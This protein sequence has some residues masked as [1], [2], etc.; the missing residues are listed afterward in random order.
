MKTMKSERKLITGLVVGVV[1]CATGCGGGAGSSA[2]VNPTT[3]SP[4]PVATKT[5][6]TGTI[7]GFGSVYLNGEKHDTDNAGIYRDDDLSDQSNLAIGMVVKIKGE[8]NQADFVTYDEDI[9]GPLD[10]IGTNTLTVLGQ[11]VLVSPATIIDDGLSVSDFVMGDIL[12]VSGF[13]NPADELDAGYIERKAFIDV[14]EYE[15][16]GRIRNLDTTAQEF[17]IGGLRVNY[18]AAEL[19]DIAQLENNLLV[20]VEDESLAYSAGDF[21]LFA[22]EV[23]GMSPLAIDDDIDPDRDDDD[24]DFDNDFDDVEFEDFISEIIDA[25]NF[26]LNG[27]Q[28]F[29]DSGT[30]FV[31]GT[32]DM[33]AQGS[34]VEVEG[35]VTD[36]LLTAVKIKFSDN[37]ARIDGL[38]ENL[39]PLTV[40]GVV[41]LAN[42][43]TEVKDDRDDVDPF[44]LGDL[45]INNFVEVEGNVTPNGVLASEI[46]RDDD[47]ETRIRGVVTAFNAEEQTL[48]ILGVSLVVGS[49]TKYEED[50]DSSDDGDDGS[51][52]DGLGDDS[53][54]AEVFFAA[55]DVGQ[56]VVEAKWNATI[57]DNS[58]AVD[59]LEL[60][61]AD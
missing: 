46:E 35:S 26:M 12:E 9:K 34:Q 8:G 14:D 49:N 60:E 43:V 20:E 56:T 10:A 48:S 44:G 54:T 19:D 50:D 5:V 30:R 27:V 28:V 52:D 32:A 33:L 58:I 53:I 21:Q 45:M 36:G 59:E 23:E 7:T 11:T 47:D 24:G 2:P 41:I 16:V 31:F 51:N 18:A 1:L 25:N 55:L 40:F 15:V 37:V 17:T 39:N 42:S 4:A 13:R 22:T 29:H 61:D 57:T 6:S 38:V 3:N